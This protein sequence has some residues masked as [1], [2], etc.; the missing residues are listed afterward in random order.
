M[1]KLII[2]ARVNEYQ[3]RAVN[4]KVP[5]S[6]AEIGEDAAQ[7]RA[8]GA[9]VV[10]FH[11][12]SPDGAPDHSYETYASS[13]RQVR[14]RSDI[15]VHPT[16]GYVT[17]DAS[18]EARLS[19]IIALAA[20]PET[21]P[22]FAPMDMG[23]VNVDWY[24]PENL[25]FD[26]DDLIYK[27]DTQTLRYFA[28]HITAANLK[29]YQ[30]AWNVSF[31]RQTE[32]FLDMGLIPEPAYLLLLLSDGTML[33]GHPG[34][35]RGLDAH[36]AF[37]PKGKAVEWTVCNYNGDLFRVTEKVIREGG[38]ISIGLGDYPYPEYGLPN[39]ATLIRMVREQ[40]ARLGRE[41]AS[42]DETR[43]LLAMQS[44]GQA[45]IIIATLAPAAGPS[46]PAGVRCLGN[47][48][49]GR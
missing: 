3:S 23:S 32:A 20:D 38:H 2:E 19:N 40:A 7:C 26:T 1:K 44:P 30:V 25:R 46:E 15:L 43:D 6:P 29:Q 5:W 42:L 11:A 41:V 48:R 47:I 17:L 13:V 18:P 39:N 14:Q 12:R 16:L 24:D 10:H 4:P 22:D 31:T 49:P 34:T 36:T 21:R 37:L 28:T 45:P 8:E 33:A 35:A 9:T 27:N